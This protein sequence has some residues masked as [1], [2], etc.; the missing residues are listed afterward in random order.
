LY[1]ADRQGS[2]GECWPSIQ[3]MARDLTMSRNTVK[4]AVNDLIR[5]GYVRRE[6]AFNKY[7]G[8]T[9]NRYHVLR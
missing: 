9:S 6:A 3:S 7:Q 2:N 5:L 1:L 8:Q 4:R